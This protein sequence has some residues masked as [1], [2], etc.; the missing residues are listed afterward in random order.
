MK[1]F[2]HTIYQYVVGFKNLLKHIVMINIAMKNYR[3]FGSRKPNIKHTRIPSVLQGYC[4]EDGWLGCGGCKFHRSF[5]GI[6]E[7]ET[8]CVCPLN[9]PECSY[10]SLYK[11]ESK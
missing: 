7:I 11:K 2:I 1:H 6:F 5:G 9:H 8:S 3:P 10:T 4:L